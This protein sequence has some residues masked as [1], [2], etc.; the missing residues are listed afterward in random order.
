MNISLNWLTEY[1]DVSLPAAELGELFTRIGLNCEGI[2]ETASDIV[3]D[4]EVTSNRPDLLGHLGV[5]RE[6]AAALSTEFRAPQIKL[7]KTDATAAE[8]TSVEV[9]DDELC[10]R[11][12]ARVIRNVKIGASPQWLVDYL[13]AIGM[14]SVNNV[15]DVTNF[16]LMEYSQPLHSFDYD[17]LSENRIIVRRAKKGE[18]I[19]SIDETTC[20]LDEKMCIIAD[21]DK[22]VAIAGVMGGLDTEVTEATT[23][24]LIESAQFDPLTTRYTSR[25][26]GVMSESN[27]RFERCIDS[28]AVDEASQRACAMICELTGGTLAD[29]VVDVWAKPYEAPTVTLRTA[30]T[31][32]LLGIVTT[33]ERQCEIL[34]GLGLGAK[35]DGDNGAKITCAIPPYRSDLTREVDL[36]EEVARIV[37][38]DN[39]PVGHSV[40]HRVRPKGTVERIRTATAE[41][42]TRAGFDESITFSF[43]DA[44]DAACFGFDETVNVDA[45]VR[46]TNN[47]L[48]P[49]LLPSLLRAIKSNQAVG[50]TS[51]SLFELAAVFP[52]SK[53]RAL[54][55]E[56]T[57]LA[58][59]TTQDL[60]D[61]RGALEYTIQRIAPQVSL[62][63]R[64]ENAPGFED[65]ISAVILLNDESAG[66]IGL[67]SGDVQNRFDVEKPVAAARIKFDVLTKF[68]NLTRTAHLL[69]KFPPVNRD[70]SLLLDED[71]TWGQLSDVVETIAQPLRISVDYV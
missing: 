45:N 10:P 71:V 64:P 56:F 26:L 67:I 34:T 60:R 2:T 52:P 65:G 69:P 62:T 51:V 28:V 13:E 8:L 66:A 37:G 46:K 41:A 12:T 20:Q 30:R 38:F 43:I 40:T 32:K 39:L 21:A 42:L 5:A 48:R 15:V 35:L 19:V 17:K 58:I 25:K 54:P 59:M 63:I 9:L 29:G 4:L 31:D 18:T 49:T 3:F 68:A 55:D 14:R 7:P 70:L 53:N 11:Y 57:E 23:N 1:V 24:L 16:V 47:A 27:Y 61:L 50:N 33:P 36:I 6:L 22:P 44:P